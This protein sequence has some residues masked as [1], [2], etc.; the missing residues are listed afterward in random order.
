MLVTNLMKMRQLVEKLLENESVHEREV[1]IKLP[2]LV[3]KGNYLKE[4]DVKY[5]RPSE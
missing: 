5:Y 1:N 3:R 4:C 2:F